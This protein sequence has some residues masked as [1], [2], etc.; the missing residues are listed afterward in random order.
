MRFE[1]LSQAG[2]DKFAYERIGNSGT[3]NLL[4]LLRKNTTDRGLDAS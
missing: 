3:Q 2:Q 4:I 1:S